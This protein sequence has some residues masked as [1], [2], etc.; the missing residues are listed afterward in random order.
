[1]MQPIGANALPAPLT[2]ESFEHATLESRMRLQHGDDDFGEKCENV[3]QD[4]PQRGH[5]R[6]RSLE[7]ISAV[8]ASLLK[9]DQ[10]IELVENLVV[11]IN[12]TFAAQTDTVTVNLPLSDDTWTFVEME[13]R[14]GLQH[15]DDDIV[16]D[17]EDE[18]SGT[19]VAYTF[20]EIE[21]RFALHHEG[22]TIEDGSTPSNAP[23][24]Q[25]MIGVV[26]LADFVSGLVSLSPN[27][28]TFTKAAVVGTFAALSK[29]ERK[30]FGIQRLPGASIVN[31][32]LGSIVLKHKVQIGATKLVDFLK[33]IEFQD[34]QTTLDAMTEAFK[35][36]SEAEMAFDQSPAGKSLVRVLCKWG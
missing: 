16:N 18:V 36:S 30:F 9:V 22:D 15:G 8:D 21:S 6:Q 34:G 32:L 28:E 2:M 14:F 7:A 19:E 33:L 23:A 31:R 26:S 25:I 3:V 10:E 20:A 24:H 12:A 11:D 35:A 17:N 5:F 1:M 29:H 13:S 27:G 4:K